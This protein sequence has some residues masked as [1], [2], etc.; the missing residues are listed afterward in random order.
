M[1]SLKLAEW[2]YEPVTDPMMRETSV[3]DGLQPVCE[4]LTTYIP[5]QNF[6]FKLPLGQSAVMGHGSGVHVEHYKRK[7]TIL[8]KIFRCKFQRIKI[9]ILSHIENKKKLSCQH[10]L[11]SAASFHK[12]NLKF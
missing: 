1:V 9:Q 7:T 11:D 4:K 2:R 6:G 8:L 5:G 3:S 12:G 10:F